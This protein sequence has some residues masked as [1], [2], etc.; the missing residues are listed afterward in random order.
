[1]SKQCYCI[2]ISN[3]DITEYMKEHFSTSHFYNK[4]KYLKSREVNQLKRKIFINTLIIITHYIYIE[5]SLDS[6]IH[7]LQYHH[8][9]ES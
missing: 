4:V 2:Q 7:S 8:R 6:R 3:T 1:M 5:A 9:E